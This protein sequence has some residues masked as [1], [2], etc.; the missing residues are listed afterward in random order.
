MTSTVLRHKG[1]GNARTAG[2]AEGLCPAVIVTLCLQVPHDQAR[3]Q[4]QQQNGNRNWGGRRHVPKRLGVGHK[5]RGRCAYSGAGPVTGIAM[6][7]AAE[8]RLTPGGR[9][10]RG[11]PCDRGGTPRRHLVLVQRHRLT[12][13]A[14]GGGRAVEGSVS[15]ATGGGPAL[16]WAWCR[17]P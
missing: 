2:L 1:S 12:K 16:S 5:H 13:H 14:C 7:G 17:I 10:R 9:G 11:M 4:Q 6:G 8:P 15:V 3:W